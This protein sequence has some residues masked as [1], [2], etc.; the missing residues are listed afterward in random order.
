MIIKRINAQSAGAVGCTEKSA[1]FCINIICKQ[2]NVQL[3]IKILTH[4]VEKSLLYTLIGVILT[5]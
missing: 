4:R 3:H 2:I 1:T 5:V